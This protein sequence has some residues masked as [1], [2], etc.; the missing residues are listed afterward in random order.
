[1]AIHREMAAPDAVYQLLTDARE[2][3]AA[4]ER[5]AEMETG[6]GGRFSIFG[7]YIEGRH[8]E[9]VP[10][11]RVVQAWRGADWAP[12]KYSI[13]RFGLLAESGGTRLVLDQEGY[14]EGNSPLYPSWHQHLSAN[15]PEF[16]FKPFAKYL[17]QL[18]QV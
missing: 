9:L 5:P 18:V 14:P 7:G 8:I 12:E 1:M 6:E 2:F 11:K 3:A 13:V 15:W 16:Y 10:G 17:A 4:T